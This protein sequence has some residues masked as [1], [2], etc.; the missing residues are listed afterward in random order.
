[1]CDVVE[2]G[3]GLSDTREMRMKAGKL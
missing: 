1:M 2:E 3:A